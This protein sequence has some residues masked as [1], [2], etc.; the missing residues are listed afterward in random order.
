M[1]QQTIN[2]GTVANDRT[3][4]TWRDA[5]DK[6]ND[7]FSELYLSGGLTNVVHINTPAD[8]PAAVNGVR[9]LIPT[10]G[11]S[12]VY[13]IAAL[14]I[15][16]GSDRFTVTGGDVVIRGL[17]RT[18]S[19]ITT[20]NPGDMFTTVDSAF[21]C[22]F[23][24]FTCAAGRWLNF[25]N[26]SAGIKS[27]ANQNVI[28]RDCDQIATI[29]GAFVTSLRT[30]TVVN[31]TTSGFIWTGT[32]N[33]QLNMSTFL[34]LSWGGNL[35]DLGT[36]TFSLID[37][38]GNNRYVSPAGATVLSGATGSANLTSTGR[39]LV[40]SNIFNGIGTAL[41]GITTQ[42]LKWEFSGNVFADGTTKNTREDA[43]NYLLINESV[44]NAGPGVYSAVNGSNW[45]SD[46]AS[47]FSTDSAG[48]I[49]YIGLG[50]IDV[51]I[52]TAATV[53]KGGGGSALICSKI[54]I[55][56][57]SG[58]AVV[59]KTIGCT[60]NAT[61]TQITSTLLVGI[62]EG[63]K[64]QLFVSIDDGVSTIEVSNARMIVAGAE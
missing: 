52:S 9:E 49:T 60:Q 35:F 28:I 39:A 34:G 6:T 21:F 2:I 56:T 63:D 54:A 3:G 13:V 29:S 20:S 42:D 37:I 44:A 58:F 23:V 62:S 43:D 38:A 55:D 7:N 30:F 47:K 12:I 16:M 45:L 51:A 61:P 11:D 40:S 26:P 10:P 36:A 18:A 57:G 1:A 25:A 22:E 4:D 24:G 48:I 8:F 27:I 14:D 31:A 59:D 53:E 64:F 46:I 33:G 32:A 19:N 17:H 41:S 50:D 5:F 15:D